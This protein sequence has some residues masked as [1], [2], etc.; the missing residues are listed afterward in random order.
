[1]RTI[2]IASVALFACVPF[3]RADDAAP[4]KAAFAVYPVTSDLQRERLGRSKTE[5]PRLRAYVALSGN[6][7]VDD[8]REL[9]KDALPADEIKKALAPYVDRE[10]GVVY[11]STTFGNEP[12]GELRTLSDASRD[13]LQAAIEQLGRSAGFKTCIPSFSYAG[14][15]LD[16]QF[17]AVTGKAQGRADEEEKPAGDERVTVYPVRS[18]LSLLLTN[19]ADCIVV[20]HPM[21]EKDG[22]NLLSPEIQESIK[23]HVAAAKSRDTENL[24]VCVKTRQPAISS[25]RID[26]FMSVEL[27]ELGQGL[28]FKLTRVQNTPYR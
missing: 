16:A 4:K 21:L 23:K 8:K 10:N 15:V 11:F 22:D 13:A 28:G 14:P 1:M 6:E 17:A 26:R 24:L 27:K 12:T 5:A 25:E 18:I 9:R 2:L 19:N 20:V 3:A 7:L